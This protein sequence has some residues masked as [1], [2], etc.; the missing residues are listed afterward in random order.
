MRTKKTLKTLLLLLF[1]LPALQSC[2][3]IEVTTVGTVSITYANPQ[4]DLNISIFPAENPN[5]AINAKIRMNDKGAYTYKLNAGNYILKSSSSTYFPLVGFQVKTGET[6]N[7]R[8]DS[9][10]NGHVE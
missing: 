9:G 3:E 6:T 2:S 8:F 7:I 5:I 1:F 4:K 10:N